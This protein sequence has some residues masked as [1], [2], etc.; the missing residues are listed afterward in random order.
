VIDF[1]MY[2]S[3]RVELE[4]ALRAGGQFALKDPTDST[5]ITSAVQGATNLASVSVTVGGLACE[6][7]GGV[8]AMCKGSNNY[9]LCSDGSAPAAYITLSGSTTYDPMFLGLATFT[10]NMSVQQDLTMRIR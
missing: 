6:C 4:Q 1:S 10:S 8:T 5:T 9:A 7:A 3:T 2:I